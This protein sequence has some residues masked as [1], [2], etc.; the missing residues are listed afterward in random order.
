[1]EITLPRVIVIV[2]E[3]GRL[4]PDYSLEFDL[5]DIPAVGS[6]LSIQR[7]DKPRP[8]GEDLIVRAVWWRLDHPNTAAPGERAKIGTFNE[9]YVE[10]DM[11]PGPWSSDHW[12]QYAEAR[13]KAGD[14]I[15]ELQVA[16]P[17]GD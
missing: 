5:P 3:S 7:P 17:Q 6:Y 13:R 11:A 12:L 9:I 2:R 1:M 10:C 16:R 8:F 15:E 14:K 4:K